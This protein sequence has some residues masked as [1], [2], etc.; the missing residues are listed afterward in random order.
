MIITDKLPL[1]ATSK[2]TPDIVIQVANL[3]VYKQTQCI[4]DNVSFTINQGSLV[5][6]I[7]PNGAGKSTLL[8]SLI[9]LHT[10]TSGTIWIDKP[11]AHCI[12]YVPQ[13]ATIDW[14]F[15]IT[16][17]EVVMM[18]R[19]PYIPFYKQPSKEDKSI[20]ADALEMV[21]MSKLT[22]RPIGQL[23]G[24]Q[25]QRVFF[26]RALA[27]QASIYFLDEPFTGID[28]P[29]EIDL[30]TILHNEKAAGKTVIMVHHDLYTIEH[31]FDTVLVLN[32]KLFYAG[33]SKNIYQE[34]ALLDAYGRS[35]VCSF[36]TF[37]K[38]N[39]KSTHNAP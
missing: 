37:L 18:G 13:K 29:T 35:I 31:Y 22:H 20:V 21:N 32:K 26:A 2:N 15:P 23:S 39:V 16:V 11:S 38:S 36:T 5:G 1:K 9:G 34:K 12:A 30:M 6:I 28:A 27:Q 24:G 25:Q 19:Y 14:D 8:N 10:Y 4:L 7:G 17:E 3:S 33:S